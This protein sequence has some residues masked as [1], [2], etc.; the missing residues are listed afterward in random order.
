MKKKLPEILTEDELRLLLSRA[1]NPSHKMQLMLMYYCGLRVSEMLAVKVEDIDFKNEVIKVVSGKGGKDRLVPIPRP[2]LADLK[3]YVSL[4]AL[5][6]RLFHT[7][8]RNIQNVI[9]RIGSQLG[10][11]MHPHMLR[12]SYAT[13]VLEKTNNIIL[14]KDLLGH[15][16]VRTT[17][18][19]THLTTKAKKA[20]ISE[21]WR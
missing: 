17:Q 1:Y 8:A 12:H 11:R 9:R 6:G 14:V 4:Y 18:I 16:D 7:K 21:V 2:L 20:G 19:Y 5:D 15:S 10:K 13:H 3:D